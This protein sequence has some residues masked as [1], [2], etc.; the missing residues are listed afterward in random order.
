MINF[1]SFPSFGGESANKAKNH[2]VQ[3]GKGKNASPSRLVLTEK[4]K[5]LIPSIN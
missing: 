3:R 4:L 2:M 5:I 1:K